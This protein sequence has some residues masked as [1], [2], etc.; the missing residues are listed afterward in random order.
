MCGG[1][2]HC[3]FSWLLILC[4]A[5][6]FGG[7]AVAAFATCNPNDA[8]R[9]GALAVALSFAA[10]FLSKSYGALIYDLITKTIPEIERNIGA[11]PE[12]TPPVSAEIKPFYDRLV[13]LENKSTGLA[14]K[15]GTDANGQK[16]Q[17]GY[18]AA[19]SIIGTLVWGFGD[20][21]SPHLST[22]G[23]CKNTAIQAP[24]LDCKQAC[25]RA[26]NGT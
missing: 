3:R 9:G 1:S 5:L 20:L 26:P 24:V 10:L 6:S 14:A 11:S 15:L 19:A 16:I 12:T 4:I 18:L 7:I 8:G 22:W 17:N 25:L 13:M 21:A 23:S 2:E